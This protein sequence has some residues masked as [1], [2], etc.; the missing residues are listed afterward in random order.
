MFTTIYKPSVYDIENTFVKQGTLL[1]AL[2]T[3]FNLTSGRIYVATK[4]QGE[5]GFPDSIFVINDTCVEEEYSPEYFAL[6]E[7]ET[8]RIGR[9]L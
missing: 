5:T 3:D 9:K 4:N 8:I 1:I 7:G 2:E 6:Y